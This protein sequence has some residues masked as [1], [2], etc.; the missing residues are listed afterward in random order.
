MKLVKIMNFIRG[1]THKYH[2][3]TI[4]HSACHLGKI[5]HIAIPSDKHKYHSDVPR[6]IWA[7]P[8]E[9]QLVQF[10]AISHLVRQKFKLGCYIII[11][12]HLETFCTSKI[13]NWLHPP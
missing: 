9:W 4:R 10:C 11:I 13:Q 12:T 1:I 6:G 2:S 7:Y 5:A 3:A 8:W